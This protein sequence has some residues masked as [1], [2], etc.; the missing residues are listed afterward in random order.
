MKKTATILQLFLLIL[1]STQITAVAG[2]VPPGITKKE[3]T[4]AFIKQVNLGMPMQ[5]IERLLGAPGRFIDREDGIERYRWKARSTSITVSFMENRVVDAI[6]V[7]P[8]G[9][10]FGMETPKSGVPETFLDDALLQK[11]ETTS[12]YEG[13]VA[14]LGPPEMKE[15][16]DVGSIRTETYY[17]YG[18]DGSSLAVKVTAGKVVDASVTSPGKSASR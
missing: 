17:W 13:L 9:K 14:L 16:E 1:I 6:A 4:R 5:E 12:S 10:Y 8:E 15:R 3:I 7:S 2:T 18:G 11:V